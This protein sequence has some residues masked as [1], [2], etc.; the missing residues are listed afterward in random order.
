MPDRPAISWE[1][2]SAQLR[3]A[4]SAGA[5]HRR[6]AA[7]SATA[8]SPA[9]AWRWRWR[10]ARSSCRRSTASGAP[11]SPRCRINSKLHARE[12]AWIMA[13]SQTQAVPGH[14]QARRRPVGARLSAD[15]LPPILATGTADYAA[16]LAGDAGRA[17]CPADPQDEAWLFYTSGTTGRPKGAV[18]THRNLLFAC[19]CYYADI[20]YHRPAGHDPARRAADARLGPLRP[21]PHRARLAQRH[22]AG[23]VRARARVRRASPRYANV[24]MFAAPTMVSRLINHGR[25]G[26]ADTRGLKTIIYGGAPMYVADL[27]ARARAV[28]PQ[29]LPALRPGREPDDHHRPRQGHARR[30]G[31]SALRGAARQRRRGAHRRRRQG[32]RRG[33]P[34]A[35]AGRGRRDRHHA[36]TA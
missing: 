22:P 16:L 27:E 2:G 36:A 15:P 23:L 28:R 18:L 33:R 19:H 13:N 17:A 14:A 26:S 10:T 1:E 25:A 31:A 29:A 24:A 35:A 32:R 11:A 8:C 12:M 30:H 5:A 3:R 7:R 4:R 21:R 34:R 6:R 20:D 9:R